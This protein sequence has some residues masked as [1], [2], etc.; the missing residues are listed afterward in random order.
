MDA[1]EDELIFGPQTDPD[2]EVVL[3]DSLE[4]REYYTY[5]G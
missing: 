3:P 4:S 1:G 2:V 5:H